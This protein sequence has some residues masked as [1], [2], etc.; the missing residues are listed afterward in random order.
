MD[1]LAYKPDLDAVLERLVALYERRAQDRIYASIAVPSATLDDFAAHH[2]GGFCDYPDPVERVAFWDRLLHERM[3][4][5]DDSVPSAYLSEFD[6]GLYGGLFGG[7]AQFM[8]HPEIGWISSMVSP[9][10][11]DWSEFDTLKLTKSSLWRQRYVHQLDVFVA[12][13]AAKFGISHFILIDGLNFIFELLG[14]TRTYQSLYECPEMVCKAIDFAH[15]LNVAVQD[16]F[17]QTVPA[18]RGGTCSN[19][20]QWIPG[21]IVSESV[22]PFHMTSVDYF[23]T[24]GREPAERMLRHYD[25]GVLHIHGNGRHLL[26]AVRSLKGLKAIFLADDTGFPLAFEVLDDLSARLG[27]VPLIVGAEYGRFVEKLRQ[28]ALVGGVF[29]QVMGAPNAD[30]ANRLMDEVRSYRT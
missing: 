26:E 21:R 8:C 24:W 19:M 1:H 15:D 11:K 18:L 5:Q 7:E 30:V 3:A 17:F 25:G 29:Y 9:L 10:L 14:A 13:A 12:G 6:Q 2:A 4:I 20:V 28:H 23:E 16:L 22:D 27:D